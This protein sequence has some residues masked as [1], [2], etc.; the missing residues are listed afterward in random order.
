MPNVLGLINA[1]YKRS[2]IV[3]FLFNLLAAEYLC[4]RKQSDWKL[5]A[6]AMARRCKQLCD[7]GADNACRRVI[8]YLITTSPT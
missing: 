5:S 4:R 8:C 1:V 3:F 6:L 7:M 2:S